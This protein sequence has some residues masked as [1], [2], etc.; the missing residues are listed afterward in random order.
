MRK[1][2]G[3]GLA[4]L[5]PEDIRT[6]AE[7]TPHFLE[8]SQIRPNP[9]QPRSDPT[10][11]LSDLVASIKEKGIL[12]PVVVRMRRDGYE[13][14][15]GERRLRAAQLAGLTQIP[16]VVKDVSESEMLEL[17]IIENLQRS[18]LNPIE[19]A[20]AYKRLAEEFNL[21]HEDIAL[22]VG[23]D[24]STIT[25]ALRLLTLPQSVRDALSR[26]EISAG[27]GR[28]LL[29]ITN[30]QRQEEICQR[31]IN[32]GL[33][34]R[35]VEQLVSPV[36][37]KQA[38]IKERDPNIVALEENLQEFFRTRVRIEWRESVEKGNIVI[39]FFS[40]DDLNRIIKKIKNE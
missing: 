15:V 23:K 38:Q 18:D 7:E 8:L 34:V 37:K 35:Q 32:E 26:K 39:E 20:L 2:L 9:Y 40:L 21:T 33:S 3:K 12:Q 17:A 28:T 16:V 31:I 27:H 24:R 25:N 4:A 5:I 30:R 11:D 36:K 14:V 13:L 19:E 22:K 6:G 29:A 1:A 10:S